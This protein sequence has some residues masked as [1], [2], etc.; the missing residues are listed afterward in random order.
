L[1]IA[2]ELID[3]EVVGED[4]ESVVEFDGIGDAGGPGVGGRE[5]EADEHGLEEAGEDSG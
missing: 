1:G 3:E 4:F 2:G 5:K